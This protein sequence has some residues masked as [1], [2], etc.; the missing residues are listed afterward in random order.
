M[1]A[2]QTKLSALVGYTGL[3]GS[4]LLEQRTFTDTYNSKNIKSLCGKSYDEIYFAACPAEKWKINQNP[5]QDLA[6]LSQLREV[7]STVQAKVFVLI[8]TIDV[9]NLAKDDQ[10]EQTDLS[11]SI[12]THHPYGKH[13]Y[14]FEQ[15]MAELFPHLLIVRLPALHGPHLKKNYLYDLLNNNNPEAIKRNSCFQWYDL[16]RLED[17]IKTALAVNLTLVNL[18]PEPIWTHDILRVLEETQAVTPEVLGKVPQVGESAPGIVYRIQTKNATYFGSTV[19]NYIYSASQ[20]IDMIQK[21]VKHHILAEKFV[22]SNI[23]WSWTDEAESNS[24]LRFLSESGVR[25]LEIAPTKIWNSWPECHNALA[26]GRAAEFGRL[27]KE[28]GFSVPSFQAVLFDRPACLLL[29]NDEQRTAF[30]DHMKF[31][32]ELCSTIHQNASESHKRTRPAAI[33]VGA[34]KNRLRQGKTEDECHKLGDEIWSAL[35][36]YAES[37]GVVICLEANP[38]Q[39]GCDYLYNAVQAAAAVRRVGHPGFLLHVDLACMTLAK[40]DIFSVLQEAKDIIF[41][42]HISE[43]YLEDFSRPQCDHAAFATLLKR[44]IWDRPI[45]LSVEMKNGEDNIQRV[46]TAVH[47]VKDIYFG[48]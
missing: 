4:N 44:T 46:K 31:V 26:D 21:F 47:L 5:Q 45:K 1:A 38:P 15:W 37:R 13:R 22:I 33:V 3:V 9:Y 25:Q 8:S 24:V 19:P 36:M 6:T 30:L 35:A 43:P 29:G 42:V 16:T 28:K 32:I 2:S 23:A 39:Y 41:H 27:L 48:L 12:Q 20:S 11:T 10:D 7:L 18:F 34:P 40:D 17:D 14:M